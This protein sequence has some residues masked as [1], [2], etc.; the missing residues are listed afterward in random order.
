MSLPGQ[1]A[2]GPRLSQAF[3][4]AGFMGF[5]A[6]DFLT[7]HLGLALQHEELNQLMAPVMATRGELVAYAVKASAIAGLLAILMLTQR[8]QPRV[9]HAYLVAA[10]LSAAGVVANVFQLL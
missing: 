7:T 3:I 10:W 2:L 1:V 9:W 6:L 5:Q 8:R 4:L